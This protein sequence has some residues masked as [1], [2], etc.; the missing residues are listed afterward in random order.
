MN[1]INQEL[2]IHLMNFVNMEHIV[3]VENITKNLVQ[4]FILLF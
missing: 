4:K 2:K 1:Y 3:V